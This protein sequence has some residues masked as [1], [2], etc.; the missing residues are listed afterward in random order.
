[1]VSNSITGQRIPRSLK[2]QAQELQKR[3]ASNGV[4]IS[5]SQAY[6]IIGANFEN[7]KDGLL[8]FMDKMIANRKRKRK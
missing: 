7:Q 4:K 5:L 3:F 1:M 2:N 8:N 6:D